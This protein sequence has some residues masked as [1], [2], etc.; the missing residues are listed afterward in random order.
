MGEGVKAG[1]WLGLLPPKNKMHDVW[2]DHVKT[3]R[4]LKASNVHL[5]NGEDKLV[6]FKMKAHYDKEKKKWFGICIPE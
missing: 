6:K 1:G 3:K 2:K 4:N 5:R